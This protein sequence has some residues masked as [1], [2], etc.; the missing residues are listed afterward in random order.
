MN[1]TPL[2]LPFLACLNLPIYAEAHTDTKV[3]FVKLTADREYLEKLQDTRRRFGG[4][5]TTSF[6]VILVDKENR[7][8][9]SGKC[10]V[11]EMRDLSFT[12]YDFDDNLVE[13]YPTDLFRTKECGAWFLGSDDRVLE[14][15]VHEACDD[16]ALLAIC[17]ARADCVVNWVAVTVVDGVRCYYN[18]YTKTLVTEAG[19]ELAVEGYLDAAKETF[20]SV[21]ASLYA[22]GQGK[23]VTNKMI[24]D[25]INWRLCNVIHGGELRNA[26]LFLLGPNL[27]SEL[28]WQQL[29]QLI[30][31]LDDN[32]KKSARKEDGAPAQTAN[33]MV[34]CPKCGHHHAAVVHDS[35]FYEKGEFDGKSYEEEG[36]V[37]QL[38]CPSCDCTFAV[39]DLDIVTRSL[40]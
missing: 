7:L 16:N 19:V 20:E 27:G 32:P 31:V 24:C 30:N 21:L 38:D 5:Q 26:L 8:M 40:S 22:S 18:I 23:P 25:S 35:V 12:Y 34:F 4:L 36:D 1:Y 3:R 2:S 6:D 14:D 13:T 9:P 33:Q 17:E 10:V 11:D 39:F 37:W 15:Y 29:D 28:D